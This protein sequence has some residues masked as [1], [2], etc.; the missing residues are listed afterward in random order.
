MGG[1]KYVP[2]LYLKNA[3]WDMVVICVQIVKS[4]EANL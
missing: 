3:D 4:S 2:Y 1:I